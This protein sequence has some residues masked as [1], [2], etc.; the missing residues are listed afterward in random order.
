MAGKTAVFPFFYAQFNQFV[1][2]INNFSE[3]L[4][5]LSTYYSYL[6]TRPRITGNAEERPANVGQRYCKVRGRDVGFSSPR[7]F[8]IIREIY[9]I[10]IK[11]TEI[12]L[13]FLLMINSLLPSDRKCHSPQVTSNENLVPI[14]SLPRYHYAGHRVR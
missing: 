10:G 4:T 9:I 3:I 5:D 14:L 13:K 8:F 2:V 11:I 6:C 7:F 1:Q 12:A